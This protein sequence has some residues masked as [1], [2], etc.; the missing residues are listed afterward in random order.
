MYVYN[1][2]P[3]APIALLT[4]SSQIGTAKRYEPYGVPIITHGLTSEA[5]DQD[6]YYFGGAGVKMRITNWIHYGARYYSTITG[7]FTQQD[8]LDAPLDPANANRYAFAGGD[9]INNIDPTGRDASDWF[10]R[11][12]RNTAFLE[13]GYELFVNGDSDAAKGVAAGYIAGL[14][15][16]LL[17]A[18]A[19]APLAMS[20]TT[21]LVGSVAGCATASYVGA[22]AGA[23]LYD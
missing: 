1:G 8:A 12:G 22:N 16:G 7:T 2:T 21:G 10:E 9:P 20:S 18:R 14:G 5:H 19:T 17:C 3:G 13:A 6:P 11:A 4:S 23:S 15:I